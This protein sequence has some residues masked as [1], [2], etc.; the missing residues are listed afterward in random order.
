MRRPC[1]AILLVALSAATA[2]AALPSLRRCRHLC[3][4]RLETCA[5][6]RCRPS[7]LNK[8]CR[9][10]GRHACAPT[11]RI[12]TPPI[13]PVPGDPPPFGPTVTV[14]TRNGTITISRQSAST[15]AFHFQ[16]SGGKAEDWM[17]FCT[18]DIAF[19]QG[20]VRLPTPTWVP[21]VL[22]RRF[23]LAFDHRVTA[24]LGPATAPDRPLTVRHLV[25]PTDVVLDA[26]PPDT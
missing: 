26:V 9:R 10:D 18:D 3:A 15:V 19:L 12:P 25:L 1:A 11:W 14:E 17:W 4:E 5:T 7:Y 21:G 20:G 23:D 24:E 8:I 16:P 22:C 13:P 6:Q 2:A